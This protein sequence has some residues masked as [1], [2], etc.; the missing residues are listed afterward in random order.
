MMVIELRVF[1]RKSQ[2]H[3]II[4]GLSFFVVAGF[5]AMYV[6][7]ENELSKY[8]QQSPPPMGNRS[9]PI[10]PSTVPGR[11]HCPS[12]GG[13]MISFSI[14]VVSSRICPLYKRVDKPKIL[15]CL[16]VDRPESELGLPM[17]VIFQMH[18]GD[19]CKFYT[20]DT[21]PHGPLQQ[22]PSVKF[23]SLPAPGDK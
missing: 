3:T 17:A 15:S 18:T 6:L 10:G 8:P 9:R 23:C 16:V 5:T 14:F 13:G 20:Q 11:A 4:K 7:Y 19:K 21:V 1:I 2:Q 12:G 22:Y